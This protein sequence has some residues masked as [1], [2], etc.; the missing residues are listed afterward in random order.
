MIHNYVGIPNNM[1]SKSLFCFLA[2]FVLFFSGGI[3]KINIPFLNVWTPVKF[4]IE[5][6][7]MLDFVSVYF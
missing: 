4:P 3:D 6:D 1:V 5:K 2:D 7:L